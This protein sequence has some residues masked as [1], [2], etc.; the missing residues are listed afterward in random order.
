VYVRRF[1]LMLRAPDAL[2]AAA[3]K[4]AGHRLVTLDKRLAAAA[5]DL[6][7]ESVLLG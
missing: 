3:C 2:H 1:E 7:V 5:K 4:R 6:G